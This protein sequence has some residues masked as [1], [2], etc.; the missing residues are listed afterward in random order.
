MKKYQLSS[1]LLFALLNTMPNSIAAPSQNLAKSQVVKPSK[2]PNIPSVFTFDAN[3]I[4][5]NGNV[6]K[7]TRSNS[8]T[9]KVKKGE[10]FQ[11]QV[12]GLVPGVVASALLISPKGLSSNLAPAIADEFGVLTL[13]FLYITQKGNY[14][15]LIKQPEKNRSS[16]L[17]IKVS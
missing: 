9:A 6:I 3:Y 1:L 15:L 14:S 7:V 8:F 10:K 12:T 4:P 5:D 11:L 17:Q 13:Q 16:Y 2:L